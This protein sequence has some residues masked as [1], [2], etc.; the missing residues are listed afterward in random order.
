VSGIAHRA[1][2]Q[3]CIDQEVDRG[4]RAEAIARPAGTRSRRRRCAGGSGRRS[5]T[6]PYQASRPYADDAGTQAGLYYLG[7]SHASLSYAAF[8]RAGAYGVAAVA[9]GVPKLI[10]Y[11]AQGRRSKI[12]Y[13]APPDLHQQIEAAVKKASAGS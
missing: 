4:R 6:R 10:V 1:S 5:R 2:L 13:G 11:D 8:V 9:F 12:L 3:K 7:E